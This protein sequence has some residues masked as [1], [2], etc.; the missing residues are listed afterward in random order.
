MVGVHDDR[1]DDLFGHVGMVGLQIGDQHLHRTA[2]ACAASE[3][4]NLVGPTERLG[5]GFVETLPFWLTLAVRP[6]MSGMQVLSVP[7]RVV[8]G[9]PF[10]YGPVN[11]G[12]VDTCFL[13]VDDHQQVRAV[14]FLSDVAM[15][16]SSDF[17]RCCVGTVRGHQARAESF[18]TV[19][20]VSQGP[21][22]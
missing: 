5:D 7:V 9:D 14:A 8:R 15:I 1:A 6:F 20:S 21:P 18:G 16:H 11:L 12:A 22:A 13:V 2:P 4:Q 10:R 17:V 19:R 3:Q